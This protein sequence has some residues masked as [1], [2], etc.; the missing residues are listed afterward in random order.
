MAQDLI[1]T[2]I[3]DKSK[4]KLEKTI[5]SIAQMNKNVKG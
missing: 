5:S 3:P 4:L 1:L 2:N